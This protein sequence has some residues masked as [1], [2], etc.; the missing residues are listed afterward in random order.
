MIWSTC[1]IFAL[2]TRRYRAVPSYEVVACQNSQTADIHCSDR[3]L[4]AI[5]S[6]VWGRDDDSN[7]TCHHETL[8]ANTSCS[9][10]GLAIST[11]RISAC[12]GQSSSDCIPLH[13]ST[14]SCCLTFPLYSVYIAYTN[15]KVLQ[16][17]LT[18]FSGNPS[19]ISIFWARLSHSLAIPSPCC[20][21]PSNSLDFTQ[22]MFHQ[23]IEYSLSW[24]FSHVEEI[25]PIT[26]GNGLFPLKFP[27]M[28]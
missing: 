9:D 21:F 10:N 13:Y 8:M 6:A 18:V 25:L 20:F 19:I 3:R 2:I 28:Q 22:L 16:F 7:V 12:N 24:L 1:T 15:A 11:I 4:I 23:F 27:P 17:S 26:A 14:S 5:Q